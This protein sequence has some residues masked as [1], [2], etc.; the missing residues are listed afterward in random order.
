[1]AFYVVESLAS[2][3]FLIVLACLLSC[4]RKLYKISWKYYGLFKQNNCR[5]V[6][7]CLCMTSTAQYC[8]WWQE[9]NSACRWHHGLEMG[10]TAICCDL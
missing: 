1:M 10:R 7:T 6:C 9:Q 2:Y 3:V 4:S 5:G 8:P